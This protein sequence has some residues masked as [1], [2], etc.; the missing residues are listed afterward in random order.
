MN[1]SALTLASVL[2][3]LLFVVPALR[4]AAQHYAA[5]RAG[6]VIQLEDAKNQTVVSILPSVGDITFSMKVRGQE[7]LRWPYASVDDFRARPALSGIPFV[8]P[9][10]N[11]LD[12]QAFYANGKKYAFDMNLG[13]VRGAIPIH[14]FLTTTD[15]WQVVEVKSDARSAWVTMRPTRAIWMASS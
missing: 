14:G 6:D 8:G 3:A 2:A 13:N 11:R 10:A 7:I 1:R 12:E 9:W 15:Q 4:G 5:R